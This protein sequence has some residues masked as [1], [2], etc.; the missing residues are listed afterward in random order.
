MEQVKICW[1]YA[2]GGYKNSPSD[3]FS[4]PPRVFAQR[5]MDHRGRPIFPG[6]VLNLVSDKYLEDK[7]MRN[8][9]AVTPSSCIGVLYHIPEDQAQAI[10]DELDFRERGGY[11]RHIVEVE[12]LEDT[13]NHS[14]GSKI[15]VLVYIG[16]A[17]NPNF[18]YDATDDW[19]MRKVNIISAAFGPSGHNRDYLFPLVRFFYE[20]KFH[21]QYLYR[22]EHDVR[23]RL[24]RWR[25]RAAD[26][27]SA[28]T[29]PD[30]FKLE[31]LSSEDGLDGTRIPIVLHGWGSVEYG[32]LSIGSSF[33]SKDDHQNVY[34]ATV[35]GGI[36]TPK[37]PETEFHSWSNNTRQFIVYA[38]GSH[39]GCLVGDT[40][41]L[42]GSQAQ[43]QVGP[44]RI[45]NVTGA[46]LGHEHSLVLL[47]S[48]AVLS[49]GD[50]GYGQCCDS[51]FAPPYFLTYVSSWPEVVLGVGL[52]EDPSPLASEYWNQLV[53]EI[54]GKMKNSEGA[55]LP[56][57]IQLC[58]GIRHSVAITEDGRL[59]TWGGGRHAA[60]LLSGPGSW[61]PSAVTPDHAVSVVDVALG[62]NHTV[63]LDSTGSV[64]TWGSNNRHLQLGRAGSEPLT[65]CV[66]SL[67]SDVIWQRV[68]IQ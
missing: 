61:L 20:N 45:S 35:I 10:V 46:S 30:G 26:T 52:T 14:K 34:G 53:G 28:L 6:L 24:G 11:Q 47:S 16:S 32:Q 40:L 41:Y 37:L 31:T 29:I 54:N 59:H 13:K 58:A 65:P 62:L 50:N 33:V 67:P 57:V 39:S 12:L 42:W 60:L 8:P 56:K 44:S 49:F 64:W 15:D 21:D 43:G 22:L 25:G 17:E 38:G 19:Y 66:V 5:S 63:A 48:G 2:G 55:L 3:T 4:L 23:M 18:V 51:S 27:A 7:N 1:S 36:A 9:E 68:Y